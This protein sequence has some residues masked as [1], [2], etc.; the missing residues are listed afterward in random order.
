[1]IR[2]LGVRIKILVTDCVS[3]CLTLPEATIR[4]EVGIL[5]KSKEAPAVAMIPVLANELSDT[6]NSVLSLRLAPVTV[7]QETKRYITH[8]SEV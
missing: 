6:P 3:E 4:I 5:D 8:E 2:R 7:E 1:M